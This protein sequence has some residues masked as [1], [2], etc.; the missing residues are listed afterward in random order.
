MDE[1]EASNE[2][3]LRHIKEYWTR[4]EDEALTKLVK[5]FKGKDFHLISK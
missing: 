4:E 3:K 1:E 5:Q 2:Y